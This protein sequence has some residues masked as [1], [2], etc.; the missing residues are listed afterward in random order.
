MGL[1]ITE[2]IFIHHLRLTLMLEL[3]CTGSAKTK[4]W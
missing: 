4:V 3:M 2:L 1:I